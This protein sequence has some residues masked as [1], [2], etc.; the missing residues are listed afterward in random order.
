MSELLEAV[1]AGRVEDVPGLL[2]PLTA[3]ERAAELRELK[4]LRAEARDH[5]WTGRQER[6]RLRDALLVA[7][8]GCQRGAASAVTWMGAADLRVAEAL[9]AGPLVEVLSHQEPAWLADVAH[10]LAGRPSTAQ[11]DYPLVAALVR[12]AGCPMPVTDALTRGW[13]EAV[14]SS[15]GTPLAGNLRADP[16][17]RA[18]VLGLFE[19]TELPFV[20]VWQADPDV[21]G[22]WP[23]VLAALAGEGV[24]ERDP[25]VAAC[26]AR[27]LRGGRPR[28]LPFFL[29][30]LRR[31]ELT[32]EEERAHT[33][34]WIGMVSDGAS[35][36]AA[37]AQEVLAR[38]AVSGS[39]PVGT[40]ADMSGSALFRPEKKLVRAQLVLLGK[41]LRSDPGAAGVLLPVV[42]EAFG[43]EDTDVQDRA[44]KLVAR[45]LSAV[46]GEVRAGLASAAS[47]LSPVHRSRAAEVFGGRTAV[48]DPDPYEEILPPAPRPARLAPVA[49]SL[50]ELVEEVAAL[51][52]GRGESSAYE[53]RGMA[54]F[55]R[56]LDGL[57]RYA[58][59][60]RAALAGALRDTLAG[61]WWLKDDPAAGNETWI[62][63]LAG[64]ERVAAAALDR[65]SVRALW[66]ANA[67]GP[68]STCCAH[69]ALDSVVEARLA[70][71][72]YMVRTKS[73]PFLL[74]TPTW[75]T[76]AVD[77]D[78]LVERLRTYQRLCAAPSPVDFAQALVRVRRGG[79][80]ETVRAA[81]ALGTPEGDRL[82]AWLVEEIPAPGLKG[83]DE[84]E[85]E[86]ERGAR[87]EGGHGW[88][89]AKGRA[90]SLL[91]GTRQRLVARRDF[92]TAFRW[93]GQ[94]ATPSGACSHWS[95][96][97]TH[98]P[99]VLPEDRETLA[100]W[101]LP[102]VAACAEADRRGGA[103]WLPLGAEAGGPAGPALRLGIA[104][105]LAARHPGDRLSA[106]DALL[107]LTARGQLDGPQLGRDIAMLAI[108]GTV[109]VNRVADSAR[110][111]A[112]TGAYR[113]VWSV[114]GA[115][116]SDLLADTSRPGLGDLL[117]VAAECAE[118]GAVTGAATG[119]GTGTDPG[120]PA[121]A[122]VAARGGSS[123][124][125]AQAA[126][127]LTALRQ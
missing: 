108:S 46:E 39:L 67:H 95:T 126:R 20:I 73:L 42:A 5:P 53:P 114:L 13:A 55:E 28:D 32:G 41:V 27:L 81:A 33:A 74:A 77:P 93:L 112:A 15:G 100:T 90:G 29:K 98:W 31:L 124:L 72:A 119:A 116:L 26:L 110:T 19:V 58:H 63:R 80:P 51:T 35:T 54:A 43:H 70:E 118:R 61:S 121:L 12:L 76:G 111:A 91:A 65:I 6:R 9:P 96:G 50:A 36:V 82:A 85:R 66:Y 1:R 11:E 86:P 25:L 102:D 120:I 21:V 122:A 47:L 99:G 30:L 16:Q 48:A 7:G 24:L 40:L 88:L 59:A 83:A 117:S 60:D 106:V 105:G 89:G 62:V 75:S 4:V 23:G 92:P 18:M 97:M 2:K 52:G 64:V 71:V 49:A 94:A 84:P 8:A 34:D 127:L 123:R 57:V 37:L 22:D 44:L 87:S 125:T 3:R 115:A 56:A 78:V 38:L 69:A 103:W 17:A 109:K 68:R 107:V 10:R 45:H 79:A 14:S 113:T 101:L 104:Y